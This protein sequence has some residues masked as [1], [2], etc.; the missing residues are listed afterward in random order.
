M[1]A[2]TTKIISQLVLDNHSLE[3]RSQEIAMAILLIGDLA[4]A[5][6]SRLF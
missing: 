6:N 1:V 2:F 3:E 5:E 4:S